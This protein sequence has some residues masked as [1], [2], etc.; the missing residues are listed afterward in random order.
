M[1]KSSIF[2]FAALAWAAIPT[3]ARAADA[4][5]LDKAHTSVGFSVR[6]LGVSNVRGQ[7]NDFDG[8]IQLDAKDPAKSSVKVSIKAAS[9]NTGNEN[10]DKHLRSDDFFDVD[11]FPELTF[12]SSKVVK[13]GEGYEMTGTLTI[14]GVAK[15]VVIPFTLA[16]P[17]KDPWGNTRLGAEGSL[18]INRKDFNVA[19]SGPSDA[20]IGDNVK[21]SLDLEAT[22]KK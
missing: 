7:F 4:Y 11:K 21:I 1:R 17:L 6:H 14:K 19:M 9:I 22:P 2:L 8:V 16:G 5:A 13:K 20:G 15:E 18:T 10:R 3:A 12:A